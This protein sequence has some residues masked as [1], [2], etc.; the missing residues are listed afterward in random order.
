MLTSLKQTGKE[1]GREISDAWENLSGGGRGSL[2]RRSDVKSI[3]VSWG[4]P[5]L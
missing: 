3:A 2:S 5:C 1:I 4:T